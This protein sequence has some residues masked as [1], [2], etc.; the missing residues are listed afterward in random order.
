MV[1]TAEG[2]LDEVCLQV[3]SE[4]WVFNTEQDYPFTPDNNGNISI[5][6]NVLRLDQV[7]WA[8]TN[9]INRGGKLYDKLAHTNV[10]NETLYLD[11]VWYFDFVDLPEAFKQYIAIRAA[12][13]FAGRAVG[14]QEAVKYSATEESNA[15]AACIEYETQQGDY[16]IFNDNAGLTEFISYLPNKAVRRTRGVN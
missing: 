8:N 16:N 4:G 12:N 14:S 1:S 10:F 6:D 2:I 7:P 3:Q 5:P 11:V 9:V 15:R 13:L